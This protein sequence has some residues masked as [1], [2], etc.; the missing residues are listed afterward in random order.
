MCKGTDLSSENYQQAIG[1]LKERFGN[2]QV[3]IYAHM[4]RLIKIKRV[5]GMENLESLRKLYN[6]VETCL[7]NLI[8]VRVETKTYG[9]L[10]V[11]ILKDKLPEDLLVTISRGFGGDQWTLARFME[12][13]DSEL[14][15]KE[16]CLSF[17]SKGEAR[18]PKEQ[19]GMMTCENFRVGG[20]SVKSKC[21]Y[22]MRNHSSSRCDRITEISARK[23]ILERFR[24]CFVCLGAGHIASRCRSS[25]VCRKCGGKHHISI[26]AKSVEKE[27][28]G[29]PKSS[30]YNHVGATNGIL[31]QTVFSRVSSS[32]S[33]SFSNARLLLDSG[34]QRSYIS[35]DLR[36]KLGLKTIRQERI[37]VKPFGRSERLRKL[38][39]LFS[40]L[41]R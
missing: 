28:S 16:N 14:K 10:L 36:Q 20:D 40:C 26:C 41:S 19:K 6:E 13:F 18:E 25:F 4:D 3:F 29:E 9:C 22:C 21:V 34:S 8:S 27:P 37:L 30:S 12:L 31:L 11:S 35:E 38:L 39:T 17:S 32:P 24:K 1:L 2:P 5:K 23:A 33:R 7:R 15:A